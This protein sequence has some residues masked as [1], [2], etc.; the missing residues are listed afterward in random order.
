MV[1]FSTKLYNKNYLTYKEQRNLTKH[2][3]KLPIL[4]MRILCHKKLILISISR[5]V[6]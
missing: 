1:I 6:L 2:L 3:L 5:A 4:Q